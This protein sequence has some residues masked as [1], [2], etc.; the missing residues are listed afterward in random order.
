MSYVKVSVAK[1]GDNQ[2]IGGNK[3]DKITLF[4]FDDVLTFPSRDAKG[5]VINDNIIFKEGAYSITLYVTQN[6]IKSNPKSEGDPDNK[7]VMQSLTFEH[8]GDNQAV[9]EFRA[10]WLNRNI[11]AIV[12]RCSDGRKTQYGSPCAPLQ[13]QYDHS[14]DKDKNATTFTLASAQ[15]GPDQA[16]Y[17]GT[18]TLESVTGTVAADATSVDLSNGPGEYQLTTGASAAA[19]ITGCSDAVDGMVFTLLGSGGAHPS[20][21]AATATAF[22][23]TNGTTWTALAGAKITF[24]AK[25]DGARSFKFIEVSRS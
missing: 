25:K 6:T 18:I 24:R 17:N 13:M 4:D 21:I 20:T 12:E 16:I 5:I 22:L 7:G 2:G 9:L 11:G 14:D 8:P 10:N 23:L 15:K 19:E 3:K 1:P